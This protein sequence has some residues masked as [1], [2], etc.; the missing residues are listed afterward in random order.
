M[1]K[2]NSIYE[3]TNLSKIRILDIFRIFIKFVVRNL[4]KLVN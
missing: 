3:L 2:L 4:A 1:L